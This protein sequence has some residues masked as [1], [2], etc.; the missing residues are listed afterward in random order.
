[1]SVVH[2]LSRGR[3]F[4]APSQGPTWLRMEAGLRGRERD[5][6]ARGAHL[7]RHS[8]S[9]GHSVPTCRAR[10]RRSELTRAVLK[11][12]QGTKH[13]SRGQSD[14][15][16]LRRVCLLAVTPNEDVAQLALDRDSAGRIP[17]CREHWQGQGTEVRGPQYASQAQASK[18]S[19]RPLGPNSEWQKSCHGESSRNSA[20]S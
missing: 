9:Q 7:L 4:P 5:S 11:V 8:G 10:C 3:S 12:H 2:M 6:R 1:M 16:P 20:C 13:G 18:I 19:G 14:G 17:A 15:G